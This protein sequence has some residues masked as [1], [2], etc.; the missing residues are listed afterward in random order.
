MGD[1]LLE[2]LLSQAISSARRYFQQAAQAELAK[3]SM[4]QFRKYMLA[5]VAQEFTKEIAFNASQ[6]VRSVGAASLTI[7]TDEGLSDNLEKRFQTALRDFKDWVDAQ[8]KN[9]PVV[10]HLLHKYRVNENTYVGRTVM[11][12][13]QVLGA[14]PRPEPWLNRSGAEKRIN[15]M[16]NEVALRIFDQ[17]FSNQ[18]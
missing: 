14:S 1:V 4:E 13:W 16:V 5:V 11:R 17:A 9:S 2:L 10:E 8:P 7:E 3:Q 18:P 15:D 12:P 6:Y